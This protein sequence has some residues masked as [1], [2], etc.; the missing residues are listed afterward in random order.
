M[1]E[2]VARSFVLLLLHLRRLE[3]MPQQWERY[4]LV[5]RLGCAYLPRIGLDLADR[6]FQGQA[7]LGDVRCQKCGFPGAQFR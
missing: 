7:L 4:C 2:L 3:S 6:I 1:G 5:F